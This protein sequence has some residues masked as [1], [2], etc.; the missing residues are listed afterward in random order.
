[1]KTVVS[2]FSDRIE[3]KIDLLQTVELTQL[4]SVV[5]ESFNEVE[6]DWKHLQIGWQVIQ[7]G[8]LVVIQEEFLEMK[9]VTV[10]EKGEIL[11]KVVLQRYLT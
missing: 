11:Q 7:T 4:A 8:N 3:S 6:S 5:L 2:L 10:V 1:M 9:V